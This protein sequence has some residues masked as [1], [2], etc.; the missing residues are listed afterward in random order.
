MSSIL[1]HKQP[2]FL[3]YVSFSPHLLHMFYRHNRG[4][5]RQRNPAA[6][7]LLSLLLPGAIDTLLGRRPVSSGLIL[8][9]QAQ[10]QLDGQTDAVSIYDQFQV[11]REWRLQWLNEARLVDA[12]EEA[13]G[14]G[15]GLLGQRRSKKKERGERRRGSLSEDDEEED[16]GEGDDDLFDEL[17]GDF[18]KLRPKC[19]IRWRRSVD[20]GNVTFGGK[21][22]ANLDRFTRFGD[23]YVLNLAF[24]DAEQQEKLI[25]YYQTQ[26]NVITSAGHALKAYADAVED[27]FAGGR[28][29]FRMYTEKAGELQKRVRAHIQTS[30]QEGRGIGGGKTSK[31][32]SL[33]W[34]LRR[35]LVSR[36]GEGD[37]SLDGDVVAERL[38]ELLREPPMKGQKED[39]KQM[40]G[41]VAYL[42]DYLKAIADEQYRVVEGKRSARIPHPF[43]LSMVD[44]ERRLQGLNLLAGFGLRTSAWTVDRIFDSEGAGNPSFLRSCTNLGRTANKLISSILKMIKAHGNP[45]A[46]VSASNQRTPNLAVTQWPSRADRARELSKMAKIATLRQKM[47]LAGL[48]FRPD[49]APVHYA[50]DS[51]LI[52]S[53]PLHLFRPASTSA[54]KGF[55]GFDSPFRPR[56]GKGSALSSDGG[57]ID[58][59]TQEAFSGRAR[60]FLKGDLA[61]HL[62]EFSRFPLAQPLAPVA[63]SRYAAYR[64]LILNSFAK[65]VGEPLWTLAA[66]NYKVKMARPEGLAVRALFTTELSCV[67]DRARGRPRVLEILYAYVPGFTDFAHGQATDKERRGAH[68]AQPDSKSFLRDSIAFGLKAPHKN[69]WLPIGLLFD[70]GAASNAERR[71]TES[72][73]R[74]TEEES[75]ESEGE[76]G[77]KT[78]SNEGGRVRKG[79]DVDIRNIVS[80]YLKLDAAKRGVNVADPL[81]YN[82]PLSGVNRPSQSPREYCAADSLV[83]VLK[84]HLSRPELPKKVPGQKTA[85]NSNAALFGLQDE[86]QRKNNLA[87]MC[88]I[89]PP[90]FSPAILTARPEEV[91]GKYT[92]V[93]GKQVIVKSMYFDLDIREDLS[94]PDFHQKTLALCLN[95]YPVGTQILIQG[96]REPYVEKSAH[97]LDSIFKFVALPGSESRPKSRPEPKLSPS[98]EIGRKESYSTPPFGAYSFLEQSLE[99]SPTESQEFQNYGERISEYLQEDATDEF[100]RVSPLKFS[101]PAET[102]TTVVSLCL[103]TH[104][105]ERGSRSSS[106]E[107]GGVTVSE[108]SALL[109]ATK[110]QM[111]ACRRMDFERARI[112][113]GTGRLP[114]ISE[115]PPTTADFT[116]K[117]G[118]DLFA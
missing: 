57:S 54:S 112:G 5:S 110:A 26:T 23:S 100:K 80:R 98:S 75:G 87:E 42:D 18:P 81:E 45:G 108:F 17:E 61:V 22:R 70:S 13:E 118:A 86:K 62:G 15:G 99:Q 83:A 63:A 56:A 74:E 48:G 41:L 37:D 34:N 76:G 21:N 20:G 44:N 90:P 82:D 16:G 3:P 69:Y 12:E 103:P 77:G 88:P 65:L 94:L 32:R 85:P 101:K 96:F 27:V 47:A 116:D 52:V 11:A 38:V 19:P 89:L 9:V 105:R 64:P 28:L 60:N 7:V 107:E 106:R 95:L 53:A 4:R 79:G 111:E 25:A 50:L 49:A 55:S 24:A 46:Y 29:T 1:S 102:H 73:R 39:L 115:R 59:E 78:L 8:S 71:E 113:P 10:T 2:S 66:D 67:F 104:Q 40:G 31:F 35:G 91:K 30:Q 43:F 36:L 84:Q 117:F 72:E 109:P 114:T 97:P 93:D 6:A 68:Q 58:G 14:E 33:Q 92:M 51:H